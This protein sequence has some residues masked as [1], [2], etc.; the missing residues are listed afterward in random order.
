MATDVS[1]T[2]KH[3]LTTPVHLHRSTVAVQSDSL[4]GVLY[5]SG[6]GIADFPTSTTFEA[7]SFSAYDFQFMSDAIDMNESDT[8]VWLGSPGHFEITGR[9]VAVDFTGAG[10]FFESGFVSLYLPGASFPPYTL[11]VSDEA[12]FRFQTRSLS[13]HLEKIVSD[14]IQS[15]PYVRGILSM[16]ALKIVLLCVLAAVGYGIIHDQITARICAEYFTIGHPPVFGTDD[17]TLLGIGWGILATWWVGLILGIGLAIAANVGSRPVRSPQTLIKPIAKLLM[18]CAASA[19]LAGIL[20]WLIGSPGRLILLFGPLYDQ[21]PR[22]KHVA[23][24]VCGFAHTASY[25]VGFFGGLVVVI[26][27]WLSRK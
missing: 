26:R 27:V 23:F 21:V 20:G 22:E 25:F 24:Q 14:Q 11:V 2:E 19:V 3:E 5:Y 12:K 17:P 1:I 18:A 4:V 6:P 7:L 16:N 8:V 13:V 9:I 10:A 15:L